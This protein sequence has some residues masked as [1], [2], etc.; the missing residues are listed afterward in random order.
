MTIDRELF[1]EVKGVESVYILGRDGVT[2]AELL[3]FRWLPKSQTW[4]QLGKMGG[5][6]FPGPK[7]TPKE[8]G[9]MGWI[10]IDN[11]DDI[12]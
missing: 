5:L 6:S 9:Q 10:I 7:F 4:Q 2:T 8:M 12:Y 11:A 1:P 3:F